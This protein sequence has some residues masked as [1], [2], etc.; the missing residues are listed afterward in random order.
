MLLNRTYYQSLWNKYQEIQP[1]MQATLGDNFSLL[2]LKIILQEL[3]LKKSIHINFQNSKEILHEIAQ[4]LYVELALNIYI[5]YADLPSTIKLKDK[6]KDR[7]DGKQYE[8]ISAQN[9]KYRLQEILRGN[10]IN[11]YPAELPDRTY[12]I[13]V[14]K[15]IPINTGVR[16]S[17][18][19]R[20]LN[21][22]KENAKIND[23]LPRLYFNSKSVF[24][25]KKNF[26]DELK[27]KNVI[28]STY[29][30]NPR[31]EED[32]N[33]IKTIP[34]L[35]DVVFYFTP[36]YEVCYQQL[37]FP[38]KVKIETIVVFD[39]EEDKFQQIIQDKNRFGFNLVML[40]N[41]IEPIKCSQVPCWNWYK[42]ETDIVNTL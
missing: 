1:M 35:P 14:T 8:V 38:E 31:E 30:P 40:T 33:E 18:I 12:D 13:V 27:I 21:F 10:R 34:A 22:F 5:N 28:P 32:P 7:K 16:D 20:F 29:L 26:W 39:T 41:S 11:R 42:E 4:H 25:T 2:T 24:I 15:F 17:T 23:D 6:F 37:L 3:R 36:K 19:K 9:G